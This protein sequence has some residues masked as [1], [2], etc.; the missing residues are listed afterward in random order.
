MDRSV[1]EIRNQLLAYSVK[2]WSAVDLAF[3]H[4]VTQAILCQESEVA[5]RKTVERYFGVPTFPG[6]T[7]IGYRK[8]H[9]E[10]FQD[11]TSSALENY[12]DWVDRSI[13]K[14][15]RKMIENDS[16]LVG[17]TRVDEPAEVT[18]QK[19]K[20]LLDFQTK[21]GVPLCDAVPQQMYEDL[22]IRMVLL[23]RAGQIPGE[24]V[25]FYR[26]LNA[27]GHRIALAL[28]DR[29][30]PG[31]G[32]SRAGVEKL[33]QLAVLSGYVGI[34][35]KSSASAASTLLNRNF[36]PLKESW[37][38]SIEKVHAVSTEEIESVVDHLLSVS[39]LPEGKFGLESLRQYQAEV[40]EAY[41]PVLLVF[42]CDD[43]IESVIDLKRFE[44]LLDANPVLS[45]LFL[46]RNGRY[47]NDL[48]YEDMA[49]IMSE[50][51]FQ[52]LHRHL[53][54]GRFIISPDG[55]RSGCIDPRYL[56]RRM[57]E[58][59]GQCAQNRKL[60]IETKGCRNFE[61][62]RGGLS[63]PWYA[64]F[65][66]NR[67]LSIRTVG[68]DGPPVFMRIP[69]GLYAYEGFTMPVVGPSPSFPESQ[70][71][72]ARMTTRQLFA[73]LETP[74]YQTL[75]NQV[76]DEFLLNRRLSAL[77]EKMGLPFSE[78]VAVLDPRQVPA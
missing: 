77:G 51:Q 21:E 14:V 1:K 52:N 47:G 31:A 63:V 17:G 27:I 42:F 72:F 40:A 75:L 48:A 12:A 55:P 32:E 59:I 34:N 24:T 29:I 36:I 37:I 13:R 69:P 62:L 19:V 49:Q 46:P 5:D 45:V 30:D 41:D 18:V 53:A 28:I 54:S 78:L 4:S 20:L 58:T 56:S 57:I 71:R 25:N 50:R 76:G 6:T 73:A 33:L 38:Q 23:V 39:D 60:I 64:G 66:C 11:T 26:E 35:L 3:Q 7:S 22:F 74:V 65:N 70:V 68:L 67:A 2:E 10:I 9:P 15:L 44:L 43:Y 61:M 16:L 8:N